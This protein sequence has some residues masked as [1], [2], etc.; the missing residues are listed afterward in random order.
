MAGDRRALRLGVLATVAVVLVGLLGV[1]LWFLQTVRADELQA[2]VDRS[3]TRVI[4]LAPERGR[5]FDADGRIL[6]DNER[7]LTVAVDWRSI[8]RSSERAV[9]FDRLSEWLEVPASEMEDRYDAG[10]YSPF[11][12]LPLAEDV[13]EPTAIAILERVEDMPGVEIVNEWKRVYPYAPHAA[14]VVGYMGAITADQLE[15]YLVRGYLRNERVGQFGIE[16]SMEEVLH[17]TWGYRVLEVDATNRPV[18]VVEE[19]PPINGFDVQLTLDLDVQVYVEQALETS[20]RSRRTQYTS[21]PLVRQPDGT[22]APLDPTQPEVVPYK[23][24]AGSAVVKRFDTG[25]VI[26][27][28]SYPTF[29]NRWFEAG[30][31]GTKFREIFPS[32]KPDGSP[33]DPDESILVNRAVQGRYNLGSTFKPF[34]A[35]AALHTGLITP[36]ET[37]VDTGTYELYSV[38]QDRCA[39]GL[40]RCVFKNA[41]CGTGAPCVYGEVDVEDALAVSSDAFFYRIGEEILVQND[42]EPVFQEEIRAFGFGSDTGIELPYEY[43]GTVPDKE[44]KRSY[45]ERGVITEDEGRGF[46]VGDSIQMA[47]GQGLLSATPIQLNQ[48]YGTIANAGVVVQP[49]LIAA[50][51]EPGTSDGA[52]GYADLASAELHEPSA[53][54]IVVRDLEMEP[55]LLD[56]IVTGLTR[57]VTTGAGVPGTDIAYHSTTGEKL[58]YDY[59]D[60]AIPVAG[61]TGTA[62]GAGNFPWNDSSAFTAFSLDRADPFVVTAYLEKAGYGSQAAAPVVKCTFLMLSGKVRTDPVR[63]SEP[64]DVNATVAAPPQLLDDVSCFNRRGG[65]SIGLIE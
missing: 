29:D 58:F 44:L 50:I 1:R 14:H 10:F 40:I 3:R 47:I 9:I 13:D 4:Q 46:Y 35:Y 25:E 26:A 43:D 38:N 52:P 20:L 23:A 12:P 65:G 42:G 8:E 57:V 49:T 7:I 34:T 31:S 5:I 11:L 18:R 19:V 39:R 63:V 2:R 48:G 17:G 28:A 36:D 62:Q 24:P 59:P 27:M 22:L 15:D 54:P 6:A 32:T 45:A 51:W 60:D 41:L 55:E 53:A 16:R 37:Y 21:N 56:P 33:I 64:L 30:I 61:K